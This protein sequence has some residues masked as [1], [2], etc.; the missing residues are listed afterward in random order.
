MRHNL[1]A[2]LVLGTAPAAFTTFASAAPAQHPTLLAGY[3]TRPSW[4]VAGIDFADGLVDTT[5]LV[6]AANI[7]VAGVSVSASTH[8]IV[9]SGDNVTLSG[10]DFSTHG[11][12]GIYVEGANDTLRDNYFKVGANNLVPIVTSAGAQEL[13][14][15]RNTIDGGGV[16]VAGNAAAIWSLIDC[17]GTGLR[18]SFNWLKNA[19]QH[20]V[21]FR[22]GRL[23]Y[24]YNLVE[25]VGF[26]QGAH[27]NDVQFNGGVSDGSVIA[28]NT[29]FNPQPVGGFPTAGEDLQVDAQLGATITNTTVAHNTVIATG[30]ALTA[31][32]LIALHQDS[33]ANLLQ[34]VKVR[35]NYLDASGAYGPLYPAPTGTKLLFSNNINLVTGKTI[36]APTTAST[37]AAQIN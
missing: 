12:W 10:Y 2:A 1:L 19:P 6:D 14:I 26:Y 20:I 33:G 7:N 34:G 9:I 24:R 29:V 31:S 8:Q 18:V 32:Y 11:G 28:Y 25:A 23:I 21:E 13:S 5:P 16:G 15:F 3:P 22:A 17:N 36:A 4:M 30:P 35:D 27:V 37:R